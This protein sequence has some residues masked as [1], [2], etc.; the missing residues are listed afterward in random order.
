[1]FLVTL[2]DEVR[3]ARAVEPAPKTPFAR[4]SRA[5]PWSET[6]LVVDAIEPWTIRL[7]ARR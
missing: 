2:V 3:I 5:T 7:D 4:R 1:M 6:H